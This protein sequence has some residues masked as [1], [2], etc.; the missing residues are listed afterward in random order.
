M[1]AAASYAKIPPFRRTV[2]AECPWIQQ[3]LAAHGIRLQDV[4]ATV[5]S[6]TPP[7]G[8]ATPASPA[9]ARDTAPSPEVSSTPPQP[10]RAAST[11]ET[12]PPATT[13]QA[14]PVSIAADPAT[15]M[16]QLASNRAQ[17]PRCVRLKRPTVF[18]AVLDGKEVGEVSVRAGTEVQ[19]MQIQS[20][21]IG[22]AYSPDGKKANLGGAWVQADDTDL[23]E[24]VHAGVK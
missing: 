14:S 8:V 24:R 18:K 15:A 23:I 4:S 2:D 5:S 21:K 9:S 13:A 20:G 6:D 10:A 17:W 3:K 19:L 12:A 16:N 1:L 7:S 11:S 22:V